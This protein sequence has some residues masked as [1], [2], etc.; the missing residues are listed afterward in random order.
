[1]EDW[2]KTIGL[3]LFSAFAGIMRMLSKGE[4]D[5]QVK[6]II[7][8]GLTALL[9]GMLVYFMTAEMQCFIDKPMMHAGVI[10]LAGFLSTETLKALTILY[11]LRLSRI[12]PGEKK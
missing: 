6:K 10:G 8:H 11:K 2:M 12:I 9:S 3:F 4:E 1:M 5:I 7:I